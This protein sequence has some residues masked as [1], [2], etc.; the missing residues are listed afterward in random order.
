LSR[1]EYLTPFVYQAEIT[2]EGGMM[3][4]GFDVRLKLGQPFGQLDQQAALVG[5][6]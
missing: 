2:D 3:E 4:I 6:P 5:D 1:F